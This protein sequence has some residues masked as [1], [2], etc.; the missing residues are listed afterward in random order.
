MLDG[1]A[2]SAQ[3]FKEACDKYKLALKLDESDSHIY[4]SNLT[5]TYCSAGKWTLALSHA[6]KGLSSLMEKK[7]KLDLYK[8][9]K[10]SKY[11]CT[12]KYLK[13]EEYVDAVKNYFGS[14]KGRKKQKPEEKKSKA[15][16]KKDSALD[17]LEEAGT[18]IVPAGKAKDS[19]RKRRGSGGLLSSGKEDKYVE[20][21]KFR[22]KFE[23]R[24]QRT[25][26]L[27]T[28]LPKL[29]A[30]KALALKELRRWLEC[31]ETVNEGLL[32][33]KNQRSDL[34]RRE[35]IEVKRLQSIGGNTF[36]T[37][38]KVQDCRNE[39]K[40]ANAVVDELCQHLWGIAEEIP[41][42]TLP[43]DFEWV[44]RNVKLDRGKAEFIEMERR[45]CGKWR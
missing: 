45:I 26:Q 43:E 35:R 22:A 24:M 29:T 17:D 36:D 32:I 39:I 1:N 9:D 38:R 11:S 6:E 8:M 42:G 21:G 27:E 20:I 31:A 23:R 19:P 5:Q 3:L 14:G 12:G 16:S 2:K 40:R 7:V 37:S 34:Q 15:D 18:K 44:I 10:N 4:L 30:R 25:K 13:R 41:R 28:L 33:V